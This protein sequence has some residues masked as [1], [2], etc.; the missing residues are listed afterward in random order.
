MR[1]MRQRLSHF[2]GRSGKRKTMTKMRRRKDGPI[3]AR[4]VFE[5]G[6]KDL[7]SKDLESEVCFDTW[8]I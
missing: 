3:L 2:R 8:A 6:Y 7:K 5:R 1:Y 4:Q